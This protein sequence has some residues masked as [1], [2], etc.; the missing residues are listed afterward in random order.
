MSDI[1]IETEKYKELIDSRIEKLRPKLLDL[2]KRN[3]LLSTGLSGSRISCIRV[4]DELPQN[5]ILQLLTET[6]QIVPLPSL[7]EDP[8]DE[9]TK[10]FK[11]AFVDAT[12]KDETYL[13]ELDSIDENDDDSAEKA[14]KAE[15][16]L[17]DRLREKLGLPVRQ[18]KTNPSLT[19]HAKNHNISPSYDLPTIDQVNKDGRHSDNSIQ[20][21][22]LNDTL[23]RQLNA[24]STKERTWRQETGIRVL[25]VAF[26]FL[27]WQDENSAKPSY[28]PL[29]LL[30]ITLEK[31]KNNEGFEY[32]IDG[33]ESTPEINTT[34][35]LKLLND[36]GVT[37]PQPNDLENLDLDV[38]FD[39]LAQIQPKKLSWRIRRQVVIGV[40][41]STR[42][43]M[44]HDLD[45][46]Q[47]DFS[48]HAIVNNLLAGSGLVGESTPFGD[49]YEI[50]NPAFAQKV[51]FLVRDADSSQFSTI[52]DVMDGKNLAVEGPPGSGK[53]QTIINTIAAALGAGKKVLFVA[54]KMAALDVVKSRLEACG[55]GEF[56]LPL[57]ASRSSKEQV[58]QSIRDRIDLSPPRNVKDFD[59]LLASFNRKKN[60]INEY[61]K[62]ISSKF[63]AAGKTVYEILGE[64]IQTRAELSV[65]SSFQGYEN[66]KFSH[67]SKHEIDDIV[68]TANNAEQF[69]N[70]SQL[71]GNSWKKIGKINLDPFSADRILQA[72]KTCS[73]L[74]SILSLKRNL[75]SQYQL[76]PG[77]DI[78]ELKKFKIVLEKI[79]NT[80]I[81]DIK[82]LIVQLSEAS[83]FK[84]IQ[85]FIPIVEKVILL[86]SD[87]SEYFNTSLPEGLYETLKR[88]I[89]LAELFDVSKIHSH[90]YEEILSEKKEIFQKN[91]KC[92]HFLELVCKSGIPY[93][94][95]TIESL[96][97]ACSLLTKYEKEI[98]V[99]RNPEL[100]NPLARGIIEK[101]LENSKRLSA[102]RTFFQEDFVLTAI[103]SINEIQNC[104]QILSSAG[105]LSFFQPTFYQ[106]KRF[107]KSISKN[108]KFAANQAALK[109]KGLQEWLYEKE[110]FE[111]DARLRTLIGID[112]EGIDTDFD[113][114]LRV[115]TFFEEIDGEFS[116][117]IH[118]ELKKFLKTCSFSSLSAIPLELNFE[119][120][121]NLTIENA[122]TL[123][124]KL[125]NEI[126]EL[127][128]L[129]SEFAIL[130]QCFKKPNFFI[131]IDQLKLLLEKTDCLTNLLTDMSENTN[132]HA[133]L[134]DIYQNLDKKRAD[135]DTAIY[136]AQLILESDSKIRSGFLHTISN[137]KLVEVSETLAQCVQAETEAHESLESL[138]NLTG[139]DYQ[140]SYPQNELS[141]F[142]FQSSEDKE[143]LIL[144]S[145]LKGTY[146]KLQVANLGPVLDYLLSSDNK[147]KNLAKL[148]QAI[149]NH[150]IA[151][152][153]YD[154]Y[155]QALR[156]YNGNEL[157]AA[158][159]QLAKLDKEIISQSRKKLR[160][161]LA[162][163]ASPP[164]GNGRG[165]KS[166]W[167]E[168]CLIEN[169]ANKRTRYISPR[170]L[171]RRAGQALLELKPCWMLSPLAV[172]QYIPKG[173]IE[174]D[175]VIIDEA[176]QMT[177]EDALGAL[178]RGKQAM[179]V[180][181]TNQL[182][183][184]N[185]FKK[186]LDDGADD[187]DGNV[188]ELSILEMANATFR[189]ARRLRWHYRSRHS[190]LI[191]FSNRF[192]YDNDLIVFPSPS[193]NEPSMGV[194]YIK[195]EGYYTAQTNPNEAKIMVETAL[196]FMKN[197]PER[198]LGLVVLNQK[199]RDLVIQEM[200]YALAQDDQARNYVTAWESENDGLESFFIKNLENVQGDE[201]DV[202]FIGTVYGPE[203][204]NARVN[205]RFGPINGISGKRRLNV[206]FSRAKMQ[207]ITFSSMTSNDILA[208]ENTNAGVYLLKRWLEYSASGGQLEL[209]EST[210]KEAD[211]IF[212][213]YVIQQLK[214][215]G[216]E[217][218]PQ[219]GVA[220]YF[221]D[222]G[223]KHPEW[224]HGFI[225]GVECDGA[226]YHSAKSARDRDRLRQEVLEGLGWKL[227]RIWS[228]DWFND[229]NREANILR[230]IVQKRLIELKTKLQNDSN[231][232][233]K[234]M[235]NSIFEIDR[236]S[237]I[238][239][240]L[241]IPELHFDYSQLTEEHINADW[242]DIDLVRNIF[243][244]FNLQNANFNGANLKEAEFLGSNLKNATFSKSDLTKTDFMNANLQS[245]DFST[246]KLFA[247]NFKGAWFDESTLFPKTFDPIKEGLRLIDNGNRTL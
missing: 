156:N 108:E 169:E 168:S 27:E 179:V 21:L 212:E 20:T 18:T 197:H 84:I 47:F 244:K 174:F 129:T 229:P 60:E 10:T 158:R 83:K 165:P 163:M 132:A 8:I 32:W 194:S 36:Y 112:F 119:T 135:V 7:D 226:S 136:I 221:I 217:P 246:A 227:H 57:Q 78:N 52:I 147:L 6:M 213:E 75:L 40:F 219:V 13:Q 167:T 202:I 240:N 233:F 4:V 195:V 225:M 92:L 141:N 73:E 29:I 91:S 97:K 79:Q 67:L 236:T 87:L 55:L 115:L 148:I 72:T 153:V 173:L 185:F 149:I 104:T 234:K 14:V 188:T 155:G 211:S 22:L 74:F 41:P 159:K 223:I 123:I 1:T 101:A 127:E 175:L 28:A 239:S 203:Q 66:L 24:L 138:S 23:S 17:K 145:R 76:E 105:L 243:H 2:T 68:E 45:T 230:E 126:Q 218:E 198:S 133:I 196:E 3:P 122:Q 178:T 150:A 51:P 120:I 80:D 184:T 82:E 160:Y 191:K 142:L 187:N 206:L 90:T 103:T 137:S 216:C 242:E 107:Y 35:A 215:M 204:P 183:P 146:Q 44:Y 16:L 171:T 214:A 124:S 224:P 208:D 220:G 25:N 49:E 85:D 190:A 95:N 118:K 99:K 5:L 134:G 201:R 88:L 128:E 64:S 116:D 96:L 98:L 94:D 164:K 144:N 100:E 93:Q 117:H 231:T 166:E 241:P 143:G 63:G 59:S 26:G 113:S 11:N 114:Y 200:E 9:Q 182:P 109:L 154:K 152:Q 125:K 53:S 46:E 12:L 151:I 110:Q 199:Q 15:R 34:L 161:R 193:E 102:K 170:D 39:E 139:I 222:I 19:Q 181:D 30:P 86:E 176:S 69:W 172:A 81:E 37:L 65:I 42:L 180:G 210:K 56:L 186:I 131:N 140:N 70:S 235:S 209:G 177:P 62:I 192:V 106:A 58:I 245:A 50:D 48:S 189:P 54:E 238:S 237:N 71:C 205:Q 33:I 130:I 111:E 31:V 89:Q 157:N 232:S 61:I 43:A 121:Q 247:T 162:A 228:T 207:I 38:Y 77:V